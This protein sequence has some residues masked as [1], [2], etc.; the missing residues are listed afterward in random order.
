MPNGEIDLE[1]MFQTGATWS[2]RSEGLALLG[3]FVSVFV[4]GFSTATGNVLWGLWIALFW[5]NITVFF[6]AYG[7]SRH[8]N[9]I[10]LALRGARDESRFTEGIRRSLKKDDKDQR[11]A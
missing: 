7:A 10:N 6:I 9:A 4:T 2:A 8:L 3:F 1:G 11:D 5:L